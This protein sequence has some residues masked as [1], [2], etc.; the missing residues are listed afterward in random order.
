MFE[1]TTMTVIT[2]GS[3]GLVTIVFIDFL[4]RELRA[5]VP[6]PCRL[7]RALIAPDRCAGACPP[8]Q[9]C[10]V[11]STRRYLGFFRQ[12]AACACILAPAGGGGAG[13]PDDQ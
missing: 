9:T 4:I 13:V 11:V 1:T 8:G 2:M 6:A 3:L 7:V 10:V 12:A 5:A